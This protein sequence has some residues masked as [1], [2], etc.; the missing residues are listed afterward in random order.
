MDFITCVMEWYSNRNNF[1]IELQR[2]DLLSVGSLQSRAHISAIE[3]T[4]GR[5]LRTFEIRRNQR[6]LKNRREGNEEGES[7]RKK[8]EKYDN[9]RKSKLDV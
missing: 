9:G 6:N 5:Y 2:S 8:I 1:L 3:G 7:K 4:R